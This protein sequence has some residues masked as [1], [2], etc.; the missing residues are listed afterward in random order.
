MLPP[1]LHPLMCDCETYVV[2]G[3]EQWHP[4]AMGRYRRM[5][6]GTYDPSFGR[7]F[8]VY[9]QEDPP[10][11]TRHFLFY[12]PPYQDWI[13]G[14]KAC[15][16]EEPSCSGALAQGMYNANLGCPV[17]H[18]GWWAIQDRSLW[19]NDGV[20]L[21]IACPPT[22]PARPPGAPSP[23]PPAPP[24][25][26][27]SMP[28]WMPPP[29][30]RLTTDA[31]QAL[32]ITLASFSA[33]LILFILAL[34]AGCRLPRGRG[35]LGSTEAES[36]A[37]AADGSPG[38]RSPRSIDLDCRGSEPTVGSLPSALVSARV[39]PSR[40]RA[41]PTIPLA[42]ATVRQPAVKFEGAEGTELLMLPTTRDSASGRSTVSGQMNDNNGTLDVDETGAD[43]LQV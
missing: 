36:P 7:P 24:S 10:T 25:R 39:V 12:W 2:K 9:E 5:W 21:S 19:I 3:A 43:Q 35:A 1:P 42:V 31:Y 8:D 30:W 4:Q 41:C 20:E 26:P 23:Q 29:V 15:R 18:T 32:L 38:I 6:R 33:L 34:W 16:Y 28:P 17:A 27:P 11:L 22:L 13:I 37:A 40:L 14:T